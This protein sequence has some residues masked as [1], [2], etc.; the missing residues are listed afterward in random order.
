L[1]EKELRAVLTEMGVV[2]GARQNLERTVGRWRST[3]VKWGR[4]K[5]RAAWG[6]FERKGES[7]VEREEKG[8][9]R[10]LC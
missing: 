3:M 7:C 10:A 8:V 5:M 9:S 6:A 4:R 2:A 1:E